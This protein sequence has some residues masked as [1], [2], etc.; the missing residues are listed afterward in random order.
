[1]NIIESSVELIDN[2]NA[3]EL[4]KKIEIALR[5]CYKSENKICEGSAEA[6]IRN[7]IKRGHESPLEHVSITYR[8]ICDRGVSH[9]WV[10]HRLASYSQESTRY[11]NYSL[12]KFGNELTFIAPAWYNDFLRAISQFD[13]SKKELIDA[14]QLFNNGLAYAEKLYFDLLSKGLK[15]E[16][17]RAVLPNALKTDIV[18]TMNIRE[19]R[20]FFKLRCSTAAHPDIRKLAIELLNKMRDSGLGIFFEDIVYD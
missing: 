20:N 18:C 16:Q 10:R 6:L 8:V 17:A 12:D 5:N 1:M 15:P 2:I 9:E 3:K 13:A 7:A 14:G 11:C 4:I 19:L